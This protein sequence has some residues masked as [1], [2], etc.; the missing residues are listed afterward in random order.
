[1]DLAEAFWRRR[2]VRHYTGAGIAPADLDFI[3]SA[4]LSAPTAG[5]AAG[6]AIVTI[7]APERIAAAAAACGE[8]EWT[9]R[10][11]DP[12]LSTAAAHLVVCAEPDIY[13]QRYNEPDKDPAV[14]DAVPWWW[15]DAGAALMALLL[16]AVDRDLAAGFLGGHRTTALRPL[17]AI[18][19]AV[20]VV[21]VVTIGHPGAETRRRRR[22]R[23]Q[24]RAPASR[25]HD[26]R[27]H[28]EERAMGGD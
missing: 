25:V 9:E 16:A 5:N 12:W 20:I 14:L 28:G 23:R 8:G 15:V 26:D 17:L 11:F 2:M 1:M 24:R 3:V 4:G 13:R 18:P 27:W 22:R 7:T 21:G 6:I 10:G 19:D